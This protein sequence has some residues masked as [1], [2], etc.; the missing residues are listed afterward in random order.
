[1]HTQANFDPSWT[2]VHEHLTDFNPRIS[3]IRTTSNEKRFIASPMPPYT[4]GSGL[5]GHAKAPKHQG[6][7]LIRRMGSG[8]TKK[9]VEQAAASSAKTI[10]DGLLNVLDNLGS[11]TDYRKCSWRTVEVSYIEA[12]Q[13]TKTRL[14]FYDSVSIIQSPMLRTCTHDD[15]RMIDLHYTRSGRFSG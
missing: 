6:I 7:S 10:G 5:N 13:S 15:E 2:E 8:L 14:Q 4:T 12:A 1:M 9:A 11:G 3:P